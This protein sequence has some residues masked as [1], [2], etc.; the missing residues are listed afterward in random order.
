VLLIG[1]PVRE[2]DGAGGGGGDVLGV[3]ALGREAGQA[4]LGT[5]DRCLPGQGKVLLAVVAV[6]AGRLNPGGAG[7]V[8]G[9]AAGDAFAYL[10]DLAHDLVAGGVGEDVARGSASG[11]DVSEA[12]PGGVHLDKHL[13]GFG[14]RGGDVSQFPGAVEL[15]DDSCLHDRFLSWGQSSKPAEAR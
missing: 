11:P 4:G 5:V 14:L 13:P 10:D 3:T 12:D 15:R 9:L 2:Q 7:P 8:A 1:Q 6:A